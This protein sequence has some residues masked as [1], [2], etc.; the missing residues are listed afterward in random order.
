LTQIIHPGLPVIYGSTSTNIDMRTGRL[1]IGSPELSL[2]INAQNQL[3]RSYG[4]ASRGGGA[5]TN[6]STTN[7]QAGFESMFSLLTTVNNGTDFVL[8]SARIFSTYLDFSFEKFIL[9]DEITG[10]LRRYMRSIEDAN[11]LILT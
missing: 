10:I 7:A 5:L 2:Y 6:S 11:T 9:D 1:S 8:H 3:A 4:L